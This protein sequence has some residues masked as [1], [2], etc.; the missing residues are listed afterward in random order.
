MVQK[1]IW[2]ILLVDDDEDD[3]LLTRQMLSMA[4]GKEIQLQWVKTMEAGCKALTS[5]HFDAALIDYD[6]GAHT[7]LELIQAVD[8]PNYPA[9]LILLT[10]RGGYEVDLEAMQAGA[11]LYLAK[12]EVTPLLLDRSIRYAIERKQA[13]LELM[14]T[15]KELEQ[16]ARQAEESERLLEAMLAY[17]PEGITIASAP[18]VI[19][20]RTSRFA[21]KILFEGANNPQGYSMPDW[22]ARVEHYLPDG[23]TPAG[24][25]DLPLTRAVKYG[26]QVEGKELALRRPDGVLI[27][28]LCN[29]SPIRDE[30]GNITAG[31]VAWRDITERKQAEE[32]LHQQSELIELSY[33]PIFI[34]DFDKGIV[35]WNQGCE[36]LY[37]YTKEEAIGNISHTLL[38][39][40]PVTGTLET[41]LGTLECQG[42]W[43]G[44][45]RHFTKD[46]R[47]VIVET[48]QRLV[49]T[50][51]RR[52]VLETNRDIT[53]RK[54]AEQSLL[55]ARQQLEWL[56]RLPDENPN[57]VVRVSFDGTVLY[58]NPPAVRMKGWQCE[59]G[60]P[61]NPMLAELVARATA[62]GGEIV[63]DIKMNGGF[64]SI[65]VI[66]IVDKGYANIY[67]RDIARRKVIENALTQSELRWSTTLS[68]IGDAVLA[69][70][71]AGKVL[72]MN[73]VAEELT[74][75][76]LL[77][78]LQKPIQ[79]VFHIISE[80]THQV[81]ENP[82]TK[83]LESGTVVGLANH[84]LLVRKDGTEIAIDDSGA[85][86][87]D[88]N[89]N[90][91]GVV[92]VFRDITERRQKED[93]IDR[94]SRLYRTLS[95]VNEAIVRTH[96]DEI[97]YAEMCK[98]ITTGG[99]PLVWIGEV[100]GEQVVPVA[101][102]GP[103]SSYLDH[104]H[105]TVEGELGKGPTGTCIREDRAVI[106]ADF[107]TNPATFP[108][109]EAALH[110][111][112]RSSAA[113]PLRRQGKPVG[114]LTL[115]ATEPNRFDPQQVALLEQLSGDI[116]YALDALEQEQINAQIEQALRR[117]EE[118]YHSLFNGITEGFALHEII[119]D[120]DGKPCDYRFLDINPAFEKLT[121]LKREDVIGRNHNDV[122]PSDDPLWVDIFGKVAL[123]G[124]TVH[125]ENYSPTLKA[126]YEVFAYRPAPN[127]FAV[128]FLNIT[129]RREM[130]EK[131]RE[132]E[133]RYRSLFESMHEGF[134]LARTLY[135]ENGHL[136]DFEYLEV[137]PAFEKMMGLK[138]DQIVGHTAK[139]LVKHIKPEWLELFSK[140]EHTGEPANHT[141]F[142]DITHSYIEAFAFRPAEGQF[143]VIITDISERMQ[144]ENALREADHLLKEYAAKLELSNRELQDF[145]SIASHDLQEPLRKVKAFG[146]LLETS[147]ANRMD[148]QEKNYLDRM[149]Q[150]SVRMQNL[151]D[152]LLAYSRVT[153]KAQQPR[154]VSLRQV[155][156][157]VVSSIDVEI[158][159]LKGQVEV[160]PLPEIEADPLQM[161]Q[162]LQNLLSN[163]LKFHQDGVPPVVQISGQVEPENG[164]VRIEVKDNGIGFESRYLDRIF[165]PFERLHGRTEYEG[166]GIGL[167]ICKK[168]VERHHGEITAL[169][170]PG[171]G[172]TF[173]VN[174]PVKQN[175]VE[176]LAEMMGV[177]E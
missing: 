138:R 53:G 13:E 73:P 28:V 99:F 57:P 101:S 79:E 134:Y 95:Q 126:H 175:P 144:A 60:E 135:D 108:W 116:S 152:S 84:T 77:D 172:S 164:T 124:E 148:D 143:A 64:Y 102:C 129:E 89:G 113:F 132:S 128:L 157:E 3:Y 92:L 150:A 24:V 103:A 159:R 155:A 21:D 158:E 56:A 46:G 63:E 120:Q 160:G 6:L 44:E 109:R 161:H 66:P 20:L 52:L 36:Q 42:F 123:T 107:D 104:V 15:R 34:Y 2:T 121:G 168:I 4:Q 49:K 38:K 26:E 91:D 112:I 54:L 16:R 100:R 136:N 74:G 170:M 17:I 87:K 19:T 122:L 86:I 78:A 39:T 67:G 88:A 55:E 130:E 35:N 30:N 76:T 37:G 50:G 98:I 81:M 165:Q 22:L 40:R 177:K 162:L 106:N 82:V 11:T 167:A 31:V 151:I 173:I 58:R 33:E 83:V 43:T 7:G 111:G 169:S 125:F 153:T 174:L 80:A 5:G 146:G 14:R 176:P 59:V 18:D 149:V 131:L 48:R 85:P 8:P 147:L 93:Q 72:Y 114:A 115:Y 141:S 133:T 41:F 32:R 62:Q 96:D 94:L 166:T 137:N 139:G 27:S 118:R 97:L 127:Q 154:L 90:V 142:S 65:S 23:V 110:Y 12:A 140:V 25:D 145:A 117:S 119:C 61:L 105:V 47:E 29:A 171:A 71:A 51:G 75:W 9:P 163:A 1:M 69:T 156:A 45:L 10:G 68:S 70:D